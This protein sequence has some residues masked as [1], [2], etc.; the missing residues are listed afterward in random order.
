MTRD[1]DQPAWAVRLEQKMDA[2]LEA[3]TAE[4]IGDE[5]EQGSDLDGKPLPRERDQSQSLG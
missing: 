3:L 4:D 5:D 2:I 1:P